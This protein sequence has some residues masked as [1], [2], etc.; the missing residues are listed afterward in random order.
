MARVVR[1][2]DLVE[3]RLVGLGLEFV[4]GRVVRDVAA[5]AGQQTA[6]GGVDRTVV[7]HG[8]PLGGHGMPGIG[9][10][11][12]PDLGVEGGGVDVQA[13]VD[14]V[15]RLGLALHGVLGGA[16]SFPDAA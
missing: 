8:R 2:G 6:P 12:L 4:G 16:A 14:L 1:G 10:D 11:V 13:L 9:V 15:Q 3:E 5:D 7:L